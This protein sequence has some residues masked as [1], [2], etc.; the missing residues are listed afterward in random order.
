M[1]MRSDTTSLSTRR[2][3]KGRTE[4]NNGG[5][6]VRADSN[7]QACGKA[8][9]KDHFLCYLWKRMGQNSIFQVKAVCPCI[10]KLKLEIT[11]VGD[12]HQEDRL[13]SQ[14]LKKMNREVL[15]VTIAP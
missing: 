5:G 2:M 7:Q 8:I 11:M 6:T 9:N 13:E 14:L 15:R 4:H 12:N 1:L 10:I 3:G